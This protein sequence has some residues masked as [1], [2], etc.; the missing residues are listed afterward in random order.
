MAA[1]AT[2]KAAR[3]AAVDAAVAPV[4]GV[5]VVDADAVTAVA[6]AEVD[7]SALMGKTWVCGL[8]S[9]STCGACAVDVLV[10]AAGVGENKGTGIAVGVLMAP[11][12]NGDGATATDGVGMGKPL[13]VAFTP[14]EKATTGGIGESDN[15]C[16]EKGE[17]VCGNGEAA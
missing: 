2:S 11:A 7:E 12:G 3:P 14:G 17:G 13:V 4:D 16:V 9:W 8:R 6:V 15:G 10:A 1:A 5:T